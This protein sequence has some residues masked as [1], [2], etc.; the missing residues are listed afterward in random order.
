MT[1]K[2]KDFLT[3]ELAPQ[4]QT[5]SAEQP[6]NFGIMTAH[7]MVEHLIYVT[8][9]MMKRKGEPSGELNKSQ[10]YF[11]KFVDAGCPFK[12]YPKEN[13]KLNDLRTASLAE[14]IEILASAIAKFYTLFETNPSYKSYNE[15]TG[16]FNLAELELFMYQH[17]RWHL[18]QFGVLDAFSVVEVTDSI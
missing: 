14:A 6:P 7:H 10:R 1:P 15:M 2:Y 4:L 11:R 5:L 16:E 9:S 13:T 8:K 18:Y 17:C 3:Q 12:H